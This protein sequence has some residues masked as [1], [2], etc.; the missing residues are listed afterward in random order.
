MCGRRLVAWLTSP[1]LLLALAAFFWSANMVVG[2][3]AR[4]LIPPIAFNFWRWALALLI[5]LPFTGRDLVRQ[6]ALILR[7]WRI[8][9][10]LALTG[11]TVFHSFIYLGLSR[12]PA[13]NGLLLFATSPLFFVLLAWLMTGER[14]TPGQGLGIAASIAGAALVIARGELQ[15]L[16]GLRFAVGDLWL[17]TGVILWA[18]YSVLLL[19]RPAG[20][21]PLV[22]LSATVLIALLL[23]LPLYGLELWS[24]ARLQVTTASLASLAYVALFPSVLAYIF[25]NRGVREVGPNAAGV[26]LQLMPV[27]GALL[28]AAFLGERLAS[29][30]WLGGALVLTGILLA[31]RRA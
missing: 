28:A 6:R 26:T 25:W 4:D 20:L 9:G 21:P 23:L 31:W 1:Y 14:I 24:G 12:S 30:H 29:Y 17:L 5:L 18:L 15:V 3:A 2:R 27:F 11:I 16:L 22:L 13:I 8:L 7:E 19:R 10:V